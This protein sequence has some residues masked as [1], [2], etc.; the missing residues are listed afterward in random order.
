MNVVPI[1]PLRRPKDRTEQE[2]WEEYQARCVELHVA[3]MEATA[4]YERWRATFL[5][6][7]DEEHA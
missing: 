3:Q 6:K 1:R 5:P 4:A 2:L 7:K